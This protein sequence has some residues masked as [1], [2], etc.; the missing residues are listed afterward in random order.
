MLGNLLT[1][2]DGSSHAGKLNS[3]LVP[4]WPGSNTQ[5]AWDMGIQ[6][7][8]EPGYKPA[9]EAGLDAAAIAAGGC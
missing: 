7:A 4:V 8:W 5:G 3:G 9:Q 2:Q 1:I 6:P